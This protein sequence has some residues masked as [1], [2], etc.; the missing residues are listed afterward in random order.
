ME[1]ETAPFSFFQKQRS[2]KER[3]KGEREFWHGAMVAT[4]ACSLERSATVCCRG[5]PKAES[6]LD[7]L[8]SSISFELSLSLSLSLCLS[9]SL[10]QQATQ[11]LRSTLTSKSAGSGYPLLSGRTSEQKPV[12]R[13]LHIENVCWEP[14]GRGWRVRALIFRHGNAIFPS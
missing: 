12:T 4:K 2:D 7:A 5:Y 13:R 3:K 6:R 1:Q 11:Y 14:F 10:L 8:Q 9:L